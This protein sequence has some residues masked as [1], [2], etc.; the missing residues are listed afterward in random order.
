M[1]SLEGARSDLVAHA[2]TRIDDIIVD[3]NAAKLRAENASLRKQY[4]LAIAAVEIERDRADSL[5]GLR[6]IKPQKFIAHRHSKT[7]NSSS[8]VVC[9]SDWHVEETVPAESILFL[10]S[11]DL[12]I[13]DRRIAEVCS[14][15]KTLVEHERRIAKIDRIVIAALGDFISNIIH[16][17]T[18]ELSSLAP[19][20]ATRWAG[21][22]LK[23][24]I[25]VAATLAKEVVVITSVGNH[26]RSVMK[27]RIGTEN[28]HSFEQNLYCTLAAA[29]TNKNVRWQIG[30]GYL[31]VAD[32]SGFRL[33]CH[34]GH[35][36]K[37][38]GVGGI[39]VG[40]ERAISQWSRATPADL[41]LFGHHHQWNWSRGKFVSNGSLIG[42]NAYALR[43][44]ASVEAPCQS[45]V[46]ID[47][48]RNEVTRALPIFC[49]RD[50]QERRKDD[51]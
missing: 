3:V 48:R 28:D 49:D 13:A 42:Y 20:A 50:L 6:G 23:G 33:C 16:E 11:F 5:V 38:G 1:G 8:V 12:S 41:H 10:N 44:R 2:K 29:E 35:G 22:R 34:H 36:I 19:L 24:I 40:A 32:L 7:R 9:L 27:P 25:D 21:A 45:F 47:H 18:A 51:Q 14:R 39:A 4:K 26:G 46:V 43:I 31:N 37:G 30:E 15:M 17:D